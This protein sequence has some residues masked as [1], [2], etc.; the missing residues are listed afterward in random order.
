MSTLIGVKSAKGTH[1][2]FSKS[3]I[4]NIKNFLGREFVKGSE[5]N[6]NEVSQIIIHCEK[7]IN[8]NTSDDDSVA[9]IYRLLNV[10]KSAQQDNASL[11]II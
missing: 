2:S 8:E 3:A 11:I 5:I 7:I 1:T 4:K 10:L 9:D 6:V